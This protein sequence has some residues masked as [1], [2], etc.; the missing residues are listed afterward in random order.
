MSMPKRQRPPT[1]TIIV[2]SLALNIPDPASPGSGHK[3]GFNPQM[4]KGPDRGVYP[5][6]NIFFGLLQKPL[7][8]S[9]MT[10]L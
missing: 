1:L 10:I 9:L 4:F 3:T 5:P 6:G 7:C 2:V 8:C